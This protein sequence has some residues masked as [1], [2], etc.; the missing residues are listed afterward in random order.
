VVTAA[1]LVA[2]AAVCIVARV[3]HGHWRQESR[4]QMLAVIAVTTRH[5]AD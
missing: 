2:G 4:I 1:A 5:D 3:L